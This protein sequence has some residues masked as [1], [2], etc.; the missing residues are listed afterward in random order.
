[1][2][3]RNIHFWGILKNMDWGGESILRALSPYLRMAEVI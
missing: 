2:H 3:S 1:M